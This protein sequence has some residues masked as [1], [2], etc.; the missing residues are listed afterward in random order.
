MKTAARTAATTI[1]TS[2]IPLTTPIISRL[3][4]LEGFAS[5]EKEKKK[6]QQKT[7][8]TYVFVTALE[9]PGLCEKGFVY[10]EN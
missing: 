3:L 7:I 6:Q 4:L 8:N 5:C 10:C 2:V 1:T 9:G